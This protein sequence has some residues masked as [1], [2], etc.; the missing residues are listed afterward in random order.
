ML[1]IKK[2]NDDELNRLD[3][4]IETL[5]NPQGNMEQLVDKVLGDWG[6]VSLEEK[7]E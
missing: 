1:D 5:N 2:C 6:F 3:N 7:N 4:I